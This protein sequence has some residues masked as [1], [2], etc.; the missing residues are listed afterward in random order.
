MMELIK[1]TRI[2]F[3][4]KRPIAFFFSGLI[5]IIGIIGL[6]EIFLGRANMG[7][8]FAGGVAIR[9]RF[10]GPVK[11]SELRD[12]LVN[13]GFKDAELQDIPGENRILIKVKKKVEDINLL[14]DG[15]INAINKRLPERGYHIDSTTEIGPKVGKRLRDDALWAA[16]MAGIGILIYI[17]LRFRF[18]FSIGAILA[19]IHDV[20][21]IVGIFYL[22][23]KEFNLIILSAILLIAGYSLTDTVVVYDRIRENLRRNIRDPLKDVINRSLNEVLSRTLITSLTTLFSAIAI[24]IFGGEVLHDFSLAIIIGIIVGTYSSIFV[25]SPVLMFFKEETILKTR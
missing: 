2:D 16:F 5:I 18:R 15:I 12:V 1:N 9:L 10:E 13:N 7:I 11:L 20:L 14:T 21:A 19:V 3:M 22:L 25:A 4:G 17:T 6:V 23:G 8:D 24:F